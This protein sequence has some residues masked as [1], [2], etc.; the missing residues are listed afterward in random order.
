MKFEGNELNALPE[1]NTGNQDDL[2][3]SIDFDKLL[4]VFKKSIPWMLLLITA[5]SV[6][7][8]LYVRYTKP[9]YES[10][11]II[12]LAVQNEASLIGIGNPFEAMSN[13]MSSE[14][15]LI[16]SDLFFTRVARTIN[17]DVSYYYYGKILTEERYKNSP[18]RV[19]YKIKNEYFLDYPIDLEILNHDEFNIEYNHNGERVIS[20]HNFGDEISTPQWNLLIEKS[21]AFNEGNGVGKY[22]FTIN[23]EKA[24]VRYLHR[25]VKVE[26]LNLNARTIGIYLKDHNRLKAKEFLTAIDTLYLDY[27]T[28]AKNQTIEQKVQFLDNQL[29]HTNEILEEYEAYFENF[30]L[31]NRTTSV[32]SDI[33][34]AIKSLESLDTLY[35]QL[36]TEL[37]ELKLIIKQVENGEILIISP[38][39]LSSLPE[40]L[41]SRLQN[42]NSLISERNLKLQSYNEN[43]YIIQRI[44]EQ[45]K[46]TES[47]TIDLFREYES[48][49]EERIEQI[50]DRRRWVESNF[51]ELPSMGTEYRKNKRFYGMFEQTYF[52]MFGRKSELEIAR[53]GTVTNFVILSPPSYPTDPIAPQKLLIYGIGGGVGLVLS[54]LFVLIRYLLHNKINTVKELEKLISVPILGSLPYSESVSG[55]DARLVIDKNP[56]SGLSE[57]LRAIRTNM[58][59]LN[60]DKSKRIISVTSTVSGEG[61]TFFSINLGAILSLSK[62]RV[63]IVDLDMR[64]PKVHLAFEND[65]SIGGVSTV[66]IG[67]D[68]LKQSIKET[69][70]DNFHYL[71]AGTTPPNPSELLLGESFDRMLSDLKKEFDIIILD[72]PPVGLVT[73]GILAMHRA[74]LPIYVFR[75]DYSKRS[76]VQ[77]LTN[78]VKMKRFKNLS[79]VLNSVKFNQ[80]YGYGYGGYGYGKYGNGYY[81]ENS[82][83]HSSLL[84]KAKSIAGK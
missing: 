9:L 51:V 22:Y 15:E 27:T 20:R 41:T 19:S 78:L 49:L 61:K 18:F 12:K 65:G 82:N 47:G 10:R 8:Y 72:T 53:A 23:S 43:T 6:S 5:F 17:Y 79:V 54:I 70:I 56:K 81:V 55:P 69:G 50:N 11:S 16:K 45:L 83:G 30:T 28:E 1:Q 66:L 25:N 77:T 57:A 59:F 33:G 80:G 7:A 84:D 21:N 76:F 63:I 29:E 42:Y 46:N 52:G 48:I 13:G 75:S 2:L 73:D 58:D 44:D 3:E 74:D 26:P 71:P 64:K 35:A 67:K 24:V 68:D 34:S 38:F 36:K 14:I 39:T 32:E 62:N 40:I 31:T 60:P 37:A 4:V